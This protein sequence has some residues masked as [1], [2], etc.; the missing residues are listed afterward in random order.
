MVS[1][2]SSHGMKLVFLS[3][4]LHC[5]TAA[6]AWCQESKALRA[7]SSPLQGAPL[8]GKALGYVPNTRVPVMSGMVYVDQDDA[9]GGSDYQVVA[10]TFEASGGIE[11]ADVYA[12]YYDEMLRRG[13]DREGGPATYRK[14]DQQLTV[15]VRND[16][17]TL[18]VRLVLKN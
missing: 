3:T 15:S 13:W 6:P 4:A 8:P 5:L 7:P 11:A 12:F 14:D 2:F 17:G 10:Y 1:Q 9:L 18:I 16:A